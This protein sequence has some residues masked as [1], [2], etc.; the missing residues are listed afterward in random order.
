MT[1]R[2][3][4]SKAPAALPPIKKKLKTVL[5]SELLQKKQMDIKKL[6]RDALANFPEGETAFDEDFRQSLGVSRARW[7]EFSR[8]KEFFPYKAQLPNRRIIWGT[9]ATITEAKKFD[10]VVEVLYDNN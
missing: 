3:R 8:D 6:I 4:L 2:L 1:K 7:R 10:G 9:K 5:L